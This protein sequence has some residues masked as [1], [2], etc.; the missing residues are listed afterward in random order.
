MYG[1]IEVKFRI[2]SEDWKLEQS[3]KQNQIYPKEEILIESLKFLYE[4]SEC[5]AKIYK[6]PVKLA[7]S[8][9]D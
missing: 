9:Q 6:K 8:S 4:M 5:R 1:K 7:Y 2:H 3:I